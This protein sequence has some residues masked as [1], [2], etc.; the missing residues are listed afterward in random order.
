[1]FAFS[2]SPILFFWMMHGTMLGKV[3]ETRRVQ[4]ENRLRSRES[5]K[6]GTLDTFTK[7][8]D[9]KTPFFIQSY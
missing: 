7:E 4:S 8:M 5:S 2:F 9:A 1:M 6:K 3:A